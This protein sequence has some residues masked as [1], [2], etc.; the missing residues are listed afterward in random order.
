MT[1]TTSDPDILQITNPEFDERFYQRSYPDGTVAYAPS[2]T[3][4]LES[5]WPGGDRKGLELWRG[6]VGN[7]EADRIMHQAGDEG[8]YVHEAIEVLLKGNWIKRETVRDQFGKRA[9]RVLEHLSGFMEFAA[10]HHPRPTHLEAVTWC[11]DPLFAGTVDFEGE[12]TTVSKIGRGKAAIEVPTVGPWVLDWKTAASIRLTHR[13]Q[14]CAYR[15]SLTRTA[16]DYTPRVGILHLGNST[17]AG[18][19]LLE[20][21]GPDLARYTELALHT[22]H[23]YH[24][25]H[26]DARPSAKVYPE[27]FV[28]PIEE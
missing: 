17:K 18:W 25:H 1:V 6:Q 23:T 8:S 11:T 2:I 3:H 12:L 13:A 7:E 27:V 22:I 19:S 5:T 26:P 15:Y 21:S 20:I 28:L 24:L 14:I 16:P 10:L 4:I 9:R